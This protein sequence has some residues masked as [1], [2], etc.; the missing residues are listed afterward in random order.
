MRRTIFIICL[1]IL[2]CNGLFAQKYKPVT[3]KAGTSIKEN[4]PVSETYLYN[5]FTK[6]K[7]IFTEG[8]TISCLFNLN[9]LSGE[10]EFIQ[11]N[12]TLIITKKKEIVS[13]I[14]AADTFYYHGAYLQQ[15]Q[16]GPLSVF[17]KRGLTIK[18]IL[19]QGAMGTINRSSAS[20]SYNFISLNSR[21][22]DLKSTDDMVLQKMDQYFYSTSRDEFIQLNKKNI[23]NTFPEKENELKDYIRTN[24]VRFDSRED[25][26]KLAYYAG[27]L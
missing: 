21:S 13:I 17:V 25:L 16:N 8:R 3:V 4:F 7:G 9:L 11:S 24:K 6:G 14:V 27:K 2:V 10:M 12:D 18:N 5:E 20:E 26:L 1:I 19:K 22:I 23:L 15:I